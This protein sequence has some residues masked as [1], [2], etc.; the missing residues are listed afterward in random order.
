MTNFKINVTSDTV[1][2]WCYVGR[3]QLQQAQ[4]L[5]Q[6][7]HP[8]DTFTV[9]YLPFL[10]NPDSPRGPGTSVDKQQ[11]YVNRFGAARTQQIHTM[12]GQAGEGVGIGFKFGGKT[13][14]SR[15]SHR[16]VHLSK[17]Y[18]DDVLEG[19]VL[20]GLFAAYFENEADI[21]DLATLKDVATQAGIP[22]GDF[23][24]AMVDSDQ[25]GP[26]VEQA[27]SIAR[28]SG[29]RGVPSFSI[30]DKFRL[31][32]SRDPTSFLQA[33]EKIKIVEAGGEVSDEE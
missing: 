11:Y 21:N 33:F 32:G 5:W 12:L 31:G 29:I 24:K 28:A 15:D 1:C 18:G 4:R 17:T 7:Q 25:G 9:H 19:K 2:P 8:N 23:Q 3:K 26:E 27:A 22:E 6:T 13:G 30:Q 16:L 14:S 10:L 20:D